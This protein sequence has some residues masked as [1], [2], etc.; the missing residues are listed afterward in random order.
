MSVN[1]ARNQSSIVE[2]GLN[3]PHVRCQPGLKSWNSA[4][5]SVVGSP[6]IWVKDRA[7]CAPTSGVKSVTIDSGPCSSMASSIPSAISPRAWSQ[8]TRSNSPFPRAPT[9]LSGCVTRSG[10]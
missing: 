7:G 3:R 10:E 2:T 5:P 1:S 9:R 4:F 6:S 8:E